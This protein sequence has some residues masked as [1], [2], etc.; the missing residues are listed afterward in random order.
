M[1]LPLPLRVFNGFAILLFALFALY[2]YNDI[3]EAIYHNASALD[4]VLWL[5][6]YTLI[7]ILF[8][9]SLFQSRHGRTPHYKSTPGWLL[10]I[11][12]LASLTEMGRTGWGVWENLFGDQEFTMMG[13]NMSATDPRV[14]L[15]REFFGSL[16]ALAGVV[17]LWWEGQK[18]A[19]PA[20]SPGN[21]VKES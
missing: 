3:D 2:Q 14:E 17:L 6:F 5:A 18:Y 11:G 19:L 15:S 4:S 7:A 12:A 20:D 1:K 10:L 16:I 9:L 8:H 13:A 21:E